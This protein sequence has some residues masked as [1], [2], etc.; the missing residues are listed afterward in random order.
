MVAVSVMASFLAGFV[1]PIPIP[2]ELIVTSCPLRFKSPSVTNL[3]NEPV[4]AA[5][6]LN[7]V[8]VPAEPLKDV[9]PVS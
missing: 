1:F 6:P 9:I 5:E 2:V 8:S 3:P 7:S 4:E